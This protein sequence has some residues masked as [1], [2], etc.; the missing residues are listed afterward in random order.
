MPNAA[1]L[2]LDFRAV[3]LEGQLAL[4]EILMGEAIKLE[5]LET[6]TSEIKLRLEDILRV[7]NIQRE[8][9]EF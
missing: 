8:K 3:Q 2:L 4:C 6:L 5:A 9:N 1:K 7:W